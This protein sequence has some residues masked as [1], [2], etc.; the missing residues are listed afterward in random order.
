MLDEIVNSTLFQSLQIPF[1]IVC[2]I[3]LVWMI[4]DSMRRTQNKWI[5]PGFALIVSLLPFLLSFFSKV[6]YLWLFTT[7]I[8]WLL[9][10]LLRP[11]YTL[12]EVKLIQADQRMKDLE[13]KYYEYFLVKNGKI[14]PVCGLPVEDDYLICPNC[15]KELKNKCPE[16]GKLVDMNWVLCPYCKKKASKDK[17]SER[18]E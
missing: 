1:L 15:F 6:N 11:E 16:C 5:F 18:N 8:V 13:T 14:C 10:L 17:G 4:D 3:L 2:I 7:V 9:Y 12:E